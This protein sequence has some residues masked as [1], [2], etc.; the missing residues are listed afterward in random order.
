MI[1]GEFPTWRKNH[2]ISQ[3]KN[4]FK[5]ITNKANPYKWL[6]LSV[7]VKLDGSTLTNK[8]FRSN[9]GTYIKYKDD[10]TKKAIDDIAQ[11]ERARH[12]GDF[13]VYDTSEFPR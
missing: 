5:F 7:I 2:I 8:D 13:R 9:M 12:S 6:G 1:N 10:L 11:R 3:I 4:G